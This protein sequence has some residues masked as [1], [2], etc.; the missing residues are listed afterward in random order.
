MRPTGNNANNDHENASINRRDQDLMVMV[1]AEVFCH[2]ITM[3]LYPFIILES[4]ATSYRSKSI[5]RIHIENYILTVAIFFILTNNAMAFYIYIAVSKAFRRD[6]I[7]LITNYW[8]R[9]SGN[10]EITTATVVS[11]SQRAPRQAE[12]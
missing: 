4:A 3:L 5:E 1:I 12:T 9:V 7:Q 6:F 8:H 2:F 11:R 10:R